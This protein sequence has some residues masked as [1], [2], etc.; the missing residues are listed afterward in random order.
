MNIRVVS[1]NFQPSGNSGSWHLE[2]HHPFILPV[3]RCTAMLLRAPNVNRVWAEGSVVITTR[4]WKKCIRLCIHYYVNTN[5]KGCDREISVKII[6]RWRNKVL[7]ESNHFSHQHT[8]A[9]SLSL[10]TQREEKLRREGAVIAEVKRR[11]IQ[12]WRQRRKCGFL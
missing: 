7:E 6:V 4:S 12:A 3:I 8:K 5:L 10:A 1:R 11:W 9:G 2:L